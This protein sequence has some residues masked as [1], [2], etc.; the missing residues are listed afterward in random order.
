MKNNSIHFLLG[1]L[2]AWCA[3]LSFVALTAGCGGSEG[4]GAQGGSGSTSSASSASAIQLVIDKASLKADGTDSGTI[5]AVVKD[6]NNNIVARQPVA[7]ATSDSGSSLVP[8]ASPLVTDTAGKA[9]AT[10][11]VGASNV[12]RTVTVTATAGNIT[13]TLSVPVTGTAITLAG[14]TTLGQGSSGAVVA[15]L[16]NA[17]GNVMVGVP[18]TLASA[19]GNT[20][21][22]TPVTTDGTGQASFTVTGSAGGQDM[23]TAAALG[24]SGQWGVNVA[25][26]ASVSGIS[27]TPVNSNVPI[28]TATP[29][30][31]TYSIGSV[32]Q[33]GKNVTLSLT[34]GIFTSTGTTTA[35]GV[36]D[37]NGRIVVNV[38]SATAGTA[39]LTAV[40][41]ADS[42]VTA[43]ATMQF[44]SGP[45]N[46]AKI[47]LSPSITSVGVNAAGSTTHQSALKAVVRDA[48]DNPVSGA[49]VTFSAVIDPSGGSIS[50]AIATTNAAGEATSAFIAGP[51]ATGFNGVQLKATVASN[52]AVSATANLTVAQVALY[53]DLGTGNTIE[54]P[55]STTYVMPWSAIVT[56]SAR[57]APQAGA[58]VS[59]SLTAVR[60][61]KGVWVW[62]GSVWVPAALA[63]T[64]VSPS[65]PATYCLNEDVNNNNILDAGEDKNGNAK[66]DPGSPASVSISGVTAADG[67][68]A[69]SITYPKSFGSWVEV[70][71]RATIST[72]GTQSTAERTFVLPVLSGD[73]QSQTVAPPSVNA[74]VIANGQEYL[75]GPY[76]WNGATDSNGFCT[77]PN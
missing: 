35:N 3:G 33:A 55:N 7:F 58:T 27:I 71:L 72:S 34:R 29:F 36:T 4:A 50:P 24:A 21:A 10:L 44:F 18:V 23:L 60:Y 77:S 12:N 39:T 14:V 49:T 15:T 38:S 61:R 5:T 69:V 25:S 57:Q 16:R 64:S 47:T 43:N 22:Q 28:N 2:L 70:T 30:T 53:V 31:A 19:R 68:A 37:A 32:P 26:A 20:I 51:N 73:V 52:T 62:G 8:G 11:T 65:G 9:T 66:L 1:R 56:D 6:A 45:P 46:A 76:G 13:Q 41:A 75:V 54:A 42:S 74:R 17:S 67:T 59:I 63:S 48:S 40:D